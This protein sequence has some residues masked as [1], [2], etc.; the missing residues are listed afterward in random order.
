MKLN[1]TKK[2]IH[3]K[4]KISSGDQMNFQVQNKGI[5]KRFFYVCSVA[6][7]PYF[8]LVIYILASIFQSTIMVYVPQ[9]NANFFNGDAS[10]YSISLFIGV[11]LLT[12]VIGQITLYINH[13]FRAKTNCN[14]RNVLWRKILNLKPK[15][16]DKVTASTLL[17]RITID[18]DSLNEFIM[19]VILQIFFNIYLLVLTIK[20]MN[21]ISIKASF[22]LLVFVPFSLLISFVVG[23]F[24]LKLQNFSKFKMSDLMEYLSELISSLPVVK[25]FNRQYYEEERGKIEIDGYYKSQR[26]LIGLDVIS[27]IVGTVSSILPDA[28]LIIAGVQLLKNSTLTPAGWYIFYTYSGSLLSFVDQLGTLWQ[29]AKSVQGKI[30][31]VS[32]ILN[33]ENEQLD[34]Y[35][36]DIVESGD[37]IFDN[38]CFGYDDVQVLNKVSFTIYKDKTTA[39]VGYSGSGKTT[40]LKLIERIYE[41]TK[42]RIL[43]KGKELVQYNIKEWRRKVEVVSQNAPM[44][45]GTIRENI[46]YGI[47][48]EV[49]DEE[50]MQVAKLVYVD[51]FISQCPNG[52]DHD[53]GQFGSKLSGGQRQKISIARAILANPEYLILDEPT[54]SLDILSANEIVSTI[55]N[56][57]GKMTI[58]MITHQSKVIQNADH[59]VVVSQD[60]TAI[61]GQH[62]DLMDINEFYTRLMCEESRA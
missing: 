33:E 31:A 54:A 11:E 28:V 15:F 13:L 57:H 9:I 62:D 5:W 1:I 46:L 45:S 52:L 10:L 56:L 55:D 43:L 41:P 12:T 37:L 4:I 42:G 50:I 26:N 16:Y 36:N 3:E 18:T 40:I 23:R 27:Q 48:R 8:I 34:K 29:S 19:D 2:K 39:I 51:Q 17:S 21:G 61:E 38:V 44:I 30:Y 58:I 60:H 24:N 32:S 35:V 14:L 59:I 25:A 53:V 7:I 6:K 47:K 49:S 20:E 22:M